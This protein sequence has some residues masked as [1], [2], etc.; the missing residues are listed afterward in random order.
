MPV[1]V[2]RAIDPYFTAECCQGT[3]GIVPTDSSAE[4]TDNQWPGH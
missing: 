3:A 1:K 4:A 2:Y